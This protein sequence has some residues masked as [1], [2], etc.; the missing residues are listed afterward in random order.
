MMTLQELMLASPLRLGQGL[1]LNAGGAT[2]HV[3]ALLGV[4]LF[5]TGR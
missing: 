2:A 4:V 1:E 3:D 5:K